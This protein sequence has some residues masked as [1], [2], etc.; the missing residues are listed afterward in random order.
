ME[1]SQHLGYA[2]CLLHRVICNKEAVFMVYRGM[3]ANRL[4]NLGGGGLCRRAGCK[5]LGLVP[6]S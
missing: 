1:K 2:E 3:G 6:F 4:A 5:H